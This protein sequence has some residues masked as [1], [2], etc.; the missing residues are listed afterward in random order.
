MDDNYFTEGNKKRKHKAKAKAKA[1][2]SHHHLMIGSR[3]IILGH[4][5]AKV[6]TLTWTHESNDQWSSL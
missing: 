5:T 2:Q 4:S 6:R 3:T 1:K